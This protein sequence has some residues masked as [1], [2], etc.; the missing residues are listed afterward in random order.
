MRI[1]KVVRRAKFNS[2]IMY[3]DGSTERVSNE[4]LDAGK[5]GEVPKKYKP[6]SIVK[7]VKAIKP[8]KFKLKPKETVPD[9]PQEP[10]VSKYMGE[11][12][13]GAYGDYKN[14]HPWEL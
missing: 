5:Y 10:K 2:R 14:L 1:V 7:P 3:E 12:K 8:V 6:S 11:C 9:A 13:N 4:D